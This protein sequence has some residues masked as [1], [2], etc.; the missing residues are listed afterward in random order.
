MLV[1]D[2]AD[3]LPQNARVVAAVDAHQNAECRSERSTT[4]AVH[5]QLY[6]F[7]AGPVQPD[8]GNLTGARCIRNG[9]MTYAGTRFGVSS[10]HIAREVNQANSPTWKASS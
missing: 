10:L 2:D 8:R 5:E 9:T 3:R 1:R 4:T 6:I 7:L